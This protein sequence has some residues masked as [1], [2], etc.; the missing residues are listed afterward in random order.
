MTETMVGLDV[1]VPMD[2]VAEVERVIAGGSVDELRRAHER[3]GRAL[4]AAIKATL[5]IVEEQGDA[6]AA[7]ARFRALL[8][9]G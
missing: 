5:F 4:E 6:L 7:A 2:R 9:E 8:E 3:V 1:A